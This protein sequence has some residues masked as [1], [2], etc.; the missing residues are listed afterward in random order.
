MAGVLVGRTDDEIAARKADLLRAFPGESGDEWFD[1]R[2][3]RWVLGRRDE[4]RAMVDRFAE[5]GAERVMLQDFVPR[6]LEMIDVMAE[7][8]FD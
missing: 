5:A 6:D 2:E 1:A 3:P 7:L 4:A 8:L